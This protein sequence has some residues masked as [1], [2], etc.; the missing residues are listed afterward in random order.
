MSALER[1]PRAPFDSP[2]LIAKAQRSL[3]S[4][5]PRL[6]DH[7]LCFV[8][9]VS[10]DCLQETCEGK[11]SVVDLANRQK[12]WPEIPAGGT[13]EQVTAMIKGRFEAQPSAFPVTTGSSK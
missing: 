1:P 8:N 7:L 13:H 6:N 3:R 10:A 2:N 11:F 12:A 5:H 9:F 4:K